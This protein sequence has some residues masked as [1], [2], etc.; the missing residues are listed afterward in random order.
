MATIVEAS[1]AALTLLF[2]AARRAVRVAADATASRR[3]EPRGYAFEMLRAKGVGVMP[4]ESILLQ[5]LG[6]AA[7]ERFKKV[8]PLLK[9]Y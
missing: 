4:V 5:V 2:L 6:D 3:S 8:L 9:G 7:D 1:S